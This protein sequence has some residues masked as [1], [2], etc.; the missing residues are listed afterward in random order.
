MQ[1]LDTQ[2]K[3]ELKGEK[4][5]AKDIQVNFFGRKS[6]GYKQ[7]RGNGI[8]V[9]TPSQLIFYLAVP[10]QKI[11]IPLANIK[12]ITFPKSFLG[13]SRF[14]PLLCIEYESS[15]CNDIIAWLVRQPKQ[16]KNKIYEVKNEI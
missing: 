2:I 15:E 6:K 4:I 9:L 10:R 1:N 5:I 12:K 7:I 11:E 3:T 16:W 8:L 14:K 13:K